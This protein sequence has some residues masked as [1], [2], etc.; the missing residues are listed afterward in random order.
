MNALAEHIK[1]EYGASIQRASKT[2]DGW[3]VGGAVCDYL[4]EE[5]DW[6]GIIE[7]WS[8]TGHRRF[9]DEDNMTSVI[10]N[11]LGLTHDNDY[12]K[13]SDIG[14]YSAGIIAH[15]DDGAFETAWDLVSEMCTELGLR[16]CG[17]CDRL[18]G[19]VGILEDDARTSVGM[20]CGR[21]AYV[22]G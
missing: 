20:K 2:A 21:C 9:P 14:Y 18:Y 8:I 22:G 17:E 5:S 4:A 7:D 11:V 6:E 1:L 3:W 16:K 15:N 10:S 12:G 13:L 19:N